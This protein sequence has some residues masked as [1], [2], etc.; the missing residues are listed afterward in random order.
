MNRKL[1]GTAVKTVLLIFSGITCLSAQ[2]S[3]SEIGYTMS[4]GYPYFANIELSYGKAFGDSRIHAAYLLGLDTGISLGYEQGIS[5]NNNWSLG[6]VVGALGAK[7]DREPCP[8]KGK[9]ISGTVID[10]LSS[11]I[12]EAIGCGLSDIFDNE[13]TNGIG[14]SL[15]YYFNGMNNSGWSV[16]LVGGYGEASR[17]NEK[18]TDA[19]MFLK[20]HF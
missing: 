19:S 15:N 20:Y 3:E 11:S 9:N 2:A 4:T 18:R 1:R 5:G 14:L 12:G 17:S 10:D 16:S 6:F 8:D 13:T 7:D